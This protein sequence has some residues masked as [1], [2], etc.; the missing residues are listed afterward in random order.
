MFEILGMRRIYSIHGPHATGIYIFVV[1]RVFTI[2]KDE[3]LHFQSS[4]YFEIFY[5]LSIIWVNITNNNQGI[6]QYNNIN[7]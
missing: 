6:T 5:F 1:L 4:K 2:K 7:N 3:V